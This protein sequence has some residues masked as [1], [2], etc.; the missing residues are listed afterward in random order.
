MSLDLGKVAEAVAVAEAESHGGVTGDGAV[1][2]IEN[3]RARVVGM[4]EEGRREGR[5]E[6]GRG[7]DRMEE[8]VDSRG[9]NRC[10]MGQVRR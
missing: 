1:A 3:E 8:S 9:R 7:L 4:D 2:A 5:R 10:M 6:D